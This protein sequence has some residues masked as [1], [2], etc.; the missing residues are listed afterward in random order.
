MKKDKFTKYYTQLTLLSDNE[1]VLKEAGTDFSK[2]LKELN[3]S[4]NPRLL[5]IYWAYRLALDKTI[6]TWQN[7]HP[8]AI[9]T[10]L[11]LC[12]S[13]QDFPLYG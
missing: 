13:L 9:K 6:L 11:D 8:L 1:E 12:I 5:C 2:Y 3:L 7:V 10:P 4:Y